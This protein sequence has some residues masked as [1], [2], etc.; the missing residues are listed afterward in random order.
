MRSLSWSS[1]GCHGVSRTR[2]TP[3]GTVAG[4]PARRAQIT[5]AVASV[6]LIA[7][8]LLT[9]VLT[10]GCGGAAGTVSNGAASS[11]SPSST[12]HS[13]GTYTYPLD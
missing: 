2:G 1:K 8:V 7:L 4:T 6:A 11:V 9:L 10:A 5:A 12:P 3:V 13:G